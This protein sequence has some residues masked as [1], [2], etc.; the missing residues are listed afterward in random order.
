MRTQCLL[1]LLGLWAAA[2]AARSGQAERLL[3]RL[4]G[5]GSVGREAVVEA[6]VDG[7]PA[8]HARTSGPAPRFL[9]EATRRFAVDG[10]GLP[11]VDFDVGEPYAGLLPISNRTDERVHLFWFF[12]TANEEHR[13]DKEIVI[14]LN[15]GPG[16]SS[17]LGFLQENGPVQ[18]QAGTAKPKANP[19][20]WH[21]LSNVV[22]VEQ[23]VTVGFSTGEATIRNEDELAQ[24]FLGFWCSF[25]DAFGLH[26]W[27]VYAAAE[28]YGGYYGPYISS[29]MLDARDGRYFDLGGLLV[30]DGLM[31]N[32]AVQTD[33]VVEAFVEQHRELMPFDDAAR[34]HVHDVSRRCGFDDYHRRHLAYPPPGPA[35]RLAPGY[36]ALPNGTA[37]PVDEACAS[38]FDFVDAK[39]RVANPCWNVYNIRA[40]CP[41]PSA[42]ASPTS[43]GPT[44]RG[45]STRP[46]TRAGRWALGVDGVFNGTRDQSPPPDRHELPRVVDVT[47]NVVVAHGAFNYVLPLNGV[48]LG[49]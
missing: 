43:T 36:R 8:V 23:P 4:R 45:L 9:N 22:W 47:R 19:W 48:L 17:L 7:E 5:H 49:L 6:V 26:G 35:P 41:Q 13:H 37:V 31:F 38:L 40:G 2:A 18:W 1:S 46:P 39:M 44:S 29:H 42:A 3:G 16:C 14:W 15:G 34:A 28:S 20:S 21:L 11:E 10:R 12:P 33:V 30:Y 25:V 32:G 27:R 24:Q